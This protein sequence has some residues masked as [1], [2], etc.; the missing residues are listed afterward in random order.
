MDRAPRVF[1]FKRSIKILFSCSWLMDRL[2]SAF[3]G[4]LDRAAGLRV[5][6]EEGDSKLGKKSDC[7][8]T[9]TDGA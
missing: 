3:V 2:T 6:V 5:H 1:E 7:A 9:S 4:D 8:F